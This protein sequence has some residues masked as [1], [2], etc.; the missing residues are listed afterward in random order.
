[1]GCVTGAIDSVKLENGKVI[2]TTIGNTPPIGICGSGII[3]A[4]ALL[5]SSEA[6]DYTGRIESQDDF[7]APWIVEFDDLPALL[8]ASAE[9]TKNGVPIVFTQKDL[10]EVQLAKAAVAGGIM[11]LLKERNISLEDVDHV[12]LAGGFGSYINPESA[13][14]IG[15]LPGNLSEK[16][17][18][19]G[20]TSGEGAVWA[21]L[22]RNEF[23][24]LQVIQLHCSYIELSARADFQQ[25]YIEEMYFGDY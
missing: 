1:M 5:I 19:A 16:T 22:D 4:A 24:N 9:E 8:L 3:D 25:F 21:L 20:N 7:N 2:Y 6:A 12:Y 10:R 18:T 23:D 17:E 14:I 13:G 11:T 15:L